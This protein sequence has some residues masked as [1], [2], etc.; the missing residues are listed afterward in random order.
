MNCQSGEQEEYE[1]V[2]LEDIDVEMIL[3]R[4]L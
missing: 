1:D 4:K 2:T 3:A